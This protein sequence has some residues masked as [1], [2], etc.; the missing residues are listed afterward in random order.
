MIP[1]PE[2]SR[3]EWV[4]RR[5]DYIGSSEISTILGLSPYETPLQLWCRKTGKLS[6]VDQNDYMLI[7]NHLE[8]VVA[9]IFQRREQKSVKY[10]GQTF[11]HESIPWASATPDYWIMG[12]SDAPQG[13]LECKTTS[14][15]NES[16]WEDQI[17]N[18]AHTQT[19]WQ[20]GVTGL[21]EAYVACLVGA[22][23]NKF[24][25]KSVQFDKSI[26]EQMIDCAGKF[27]DM[28]RADVPPDAKG[29]DIKLLKDIQEPRSNQILL[30]DDVA[31]LLKEWEDLDGD[32]AVAKESLETIESKMADIRA[33]ITQRMDGYAVGHCG[34]WKISNKEVN[35][36]GHVVAPYKYDL[37][38]ITE[39]KGDK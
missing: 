26:W 3:E 1:L 18:Q 13:I 17:P 10:V 21:H 15:Y 27:M 39:L 34:K 4:K 22:D 31:E 2:V 5:K 9:N 14:F 38:K 29:E 12:I 35:N 30:L 7:G 25:S 37:F 19:I 24:Y 6:D 8:P 32:K 33:K 23:P 16:K 20:L 11:V 28:V 36:K